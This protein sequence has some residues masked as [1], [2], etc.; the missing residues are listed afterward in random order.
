VAFYHTLTDPA[1]RVTLKIYT[2][3]FRKIYEYS[4]DSQYLIPGQH[5]YSLD[6]GTSGL[7]IADGFYYF[8]LE[9]DTGGTITRSILKVILRK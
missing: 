9:V 5:L 4:Y 2:V 8:V 7:S 1:D 6:W 3:A